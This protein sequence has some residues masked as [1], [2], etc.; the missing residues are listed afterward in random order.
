MRQEWHAD[1]DSPATPR[2]FQIELQSLRRR[3][4][5]LED[6]LQHRQVSEALLRAAGNHF[7]TLIDS[8][9]DIV[10]TLDVDQCHTGVYGRWI[11]KTGL[12]PEFFLG[13][14]ARD[15]F[16]PEAASIHEAANLRAL[17]GETVNYEWS[18]PGKEADA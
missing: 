15:L 6:E 3:V 2:S 1:G 12:T 4:T 5:E 14:T 10:Y 7:R 17:N 8:L 16:G 13:K 11:E 9:D 18:M